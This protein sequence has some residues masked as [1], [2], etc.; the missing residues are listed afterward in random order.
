MDATSCKNWTDYLNRRAKGEKFVYKEYLSFLTDYYWKIL[1]EEGYE[2]KEAFQ[3]ACTFS[4]QY[5]YKGKVSNIIIEDKI[6]FAIPGIK[7]LIRHGFINVLEQKILKG[8]V[9]NIYQVADTTKS[10]W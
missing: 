5:R 3:L 10:I 7:T 6:G 9:V 8:H 1:K 4:G 2:Q